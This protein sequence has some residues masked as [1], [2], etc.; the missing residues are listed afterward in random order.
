[1]LNLR[2]VFNFAIDGRAKFVFLL[3]EFRL[4]AV[5][6]TLS[7]IALCAIVVDD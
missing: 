3:L 1:M 7:T 2:I 5:L 4:G 6:S